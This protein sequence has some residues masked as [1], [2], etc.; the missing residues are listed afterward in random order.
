MKTIC[1]SLAAAIGVCAVCL[2]LWLYFSAMPYAKVIHK[3]WGI[4]LPTAGERDLYSYSQPSPHGDGVRY[5]VIDYPVG[6]D[7]KETRK[8]VSRL[9]SIFRDVTEPTESQISRVEQLLE[10]RGIEDDAVP[11]WKRCS[12]LYLKQED[13]SELFLFCWLGTGTLY[14]VESFF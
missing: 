13:G 6:K 2:L 3:N 4:E 14:V 11:D 5:H 7:S 8:T 9:E 10:E 12:L 1:I